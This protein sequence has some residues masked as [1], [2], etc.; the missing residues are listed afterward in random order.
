MRTKIDYSEPIAIGK[1]AMKIVHNTASVFAKDDL[2]ELLQ[3]EIEYILAGSYRAKEIVESSKESYGGLIDRSIEIWGC[4]EEICVDSCE[5][6]SEM[7]NLP[8]EQMTALYKRLLEGNLPGLRTDLRKDQKRQLS[9][10]IQVIANLIEESDYYY[11]ITL[12][13][14]AI[15]E[16]QLND[17][18]SSYLE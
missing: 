14:F 7:E 11:C 13:D 5:D 6:S 15:Y 2:S 3:D 18:R 9:T 17:P 10:M 4:L 16:D 8:E 12:E 1:T